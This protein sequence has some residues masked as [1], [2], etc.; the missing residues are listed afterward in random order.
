MLKRFG[1]VVAVGFC[2]TAVQGAPF[3]QAYWIAVSS[4]VVKVEV[5]RPSGGYSV[6]TG[7]VVDRGKVATA[8]HVLRSG[9]RVAVLYAGVRHSAV[10][11]NT[12]AEH[13]ICLLQVPLLEARPAVLRPTSRLAIGEE[14]GAIGFSAGAGVR[15]AHGAVARLHRYDDGVVV[16]GDAAFTSG[17]SGGGLFDADMRLVGILMFRMRGA[18]AQYFSAPVEWVAGGL[19]D[20]APEAVDAEISCEPFWNRAP[21]RLPYFMRANILISE[22]R[23]DDL[24]T[25]LS[26]W[27][28]DEP[29]SAEPVFLAGELD[30]R[31]GRTAMALTEYREAVALDPEHA[32]AW[33]GLVRASMRSRDVELARRAYGRLVSLSAVLSG[34]IAV[35]FPEVLE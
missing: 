18:G 25:L 1:L 6:G 29:S 5:S 16:Q 4:G 13:D 21:D 30:S 32:L 12:S 26:Q 14:V 7:I 15:Y 11:R 24:Q 31:R 17:A 23:W 35:E 8:C 2:C 28:L 22:E 19:G 3:D 33:N 10:A 9:A 20:D 27:K 34:R